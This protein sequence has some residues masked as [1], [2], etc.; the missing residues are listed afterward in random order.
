MAREVA[1]S[2]VATPRAARC[3]A[4]RSPAVLRSSVH[5]ALDVY[6]PTSAE[7]SVSLNG[8]EYDPADV[9]PFEWYDP[10]GGLLLGT[11]AGPELGGTPI[12]V[13]GANLTGGTDRRCRFAPLLAAGQ[14]SAQ[15][16]AEMAAGTTEVPATLVDGGGVAGGPALRCVTPRLTAR[17]DWG[18]VAVE[19]SLNGQQFTSEGRR[20]R[21]DAEARDFHHRENVTH[22]SAAERS[23]HAT[24]SPPL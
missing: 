13:S 5:A 9:V 23:R 21:V 6:L 18:H 2:Y 15:M 12:V 8:A 7:L 11:N 14:A 10:P 16:A 4:P 3:V 22:W 1:A 19:V 24:L 17:S 20:F